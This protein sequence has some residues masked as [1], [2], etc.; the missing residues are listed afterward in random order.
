MNKSK[1]LLTTDYYCKSEISNL[2]F[3]AGVVNA[4]CKYEIIE[5][6]LG[7]LGDK[8]DMIYSNISLGWGDNRPKR[9]ALLLNAWDKS[10]K[11]LLS[12]ILEV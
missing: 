6:K 9:A 8:Y 3:V 7:T 2:K 10:Y 12:D 1:Y 4:K 5:Y 11:R